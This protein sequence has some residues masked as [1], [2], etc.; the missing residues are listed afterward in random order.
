MSIP[1]QTIV[2]RAKQFARLEEMLDDVM[3]GRGR[4]C[5]LAGEAGSGKTTIVGE[6][7]RTAQDEHESLL[8]VAGDCNQ[9]TGVGDPYLPF[10]EILAQLA[11]EVDFSV[12][13]GVLSQESARRL[14]SN[15]KVSGEMILRV[16]AD[17]L[18][19]FVP[20]ASLL[21]VLGGRMLSGRSEARS[22]TFGQQQIFEQYT[23][24]LRNLAERFPIILFI[25][26]L[27]WV[28]HAS[29]ELLFHLSRRIEGSRVM[30]VGTYRPNDL[31][32]R[33]SGQPHPMERTIAEVKRYYGDAVIET[34]ERDP[35]EQRRFVA[36]L[37]AS[38][39]L[40]LENGFLDSILQQTDGHP[41]FT[42][43]LLRS[44][45]EGGVLARDESGDFLV[46]GKIEWDSLP[47]R[48][49]GII[50]GR[51]SRLDP[52]LRELLLVSSVQGQEFVAEAA[53]ALLSLEENRVVRQ[54]S[55]ELDRDHQLVM[56]KRAIRV[57]EKRLSVYRFRH[58][59]FQTYLYGSLDP[60]R[61]AYLH[62]DTG[63]ILEE[64]Y[65]DH[66]SDISVQLA[67]HFAI[68]G[69]D[70][71]AG[72][73]WV[74]AGD[75]AGGVYAYPEAMRHYRQGLEA[76]ARLE[77]SE[78][79]FR[80][81]IDATV[82]LARVSYLGE[83]PNL[84]LKRLQ[85]VEPLAETLAS[86]ARGPGDALRL[87]RVQYWMGRYHFLLHA[88]KAAIALYRKV[89]EV[90]PTLNDPELLALPASVIGRAFVA[91]GRFREA[92]PLL[93]QAIG[94][95]EE[96][97]NPFE[98][99]HTMNFLGHAAAGSGLPE[100]A[101][102]HVRAAMEKARQIESP[103]AITLSW[104]HTW[105]TL[106]YAGSE[107]EMLETGR[108]LVQAARKSDEPVALYVGLGFLAWSQTRAGL[109]EEAAQSMSRCK[110]MA[111]T[112]GET[113]V[114]ADWFAAV[115][116]EIALG[117][118]DPEEACA[119]ALEA[120]EMAEAAGG[121]LAA[122]LAHR[123]WGVALGRREAPWAEIEAHF[124]AG[125]DAAESGGIRP[126]IARIHAIW[127][128]EAGRRGLQEVAEE[129]RAAALRLLDEGV[130]AAELGYLRDKP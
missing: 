102:E 100:M 129:H 75:A 93:E 6:F 118:D 87:A 67:R 35:T 1:W 11:G 121:V 28:D 12:A 13:E 55:S 90:A 113:M 82:K 58:N 66:V 42:V 48:I 107:S 59:L 112:L 22:S 29:A 20:G 92:L 64:L 74:D 96:L 38:E 86:E 4:V 54:L 79:V 119:L 50:E 26:D 76:L 40:R 9:Q 53:A 116:A 111:A 30:I 62:E 65:G 43:E 68:A 99:I 27:Q 46:R 98:W 84:I 104:I 106:M 45:A 91:Q 125:L 10:R 36:T 110:E 70:R 103:E 72:R 3:G 34:D 117:R 122:A 52:D 56:A 95:L 126:E 19:I 47:S 25:D 97:G 78:E 41:L 101:S 14:R 94:P 15:V 109:H 7:S 73:Y 17:L 114:V 115:E 44:L 23:D 21:A 105:A 88:P 49:E 60:V 80:S 124:A 89:V 37:L 63:R 8:L 83:S 123:T 16:G 31:A 128:A 39:P 18:D 32:M 33:R 127:S 61:K 108:L 24:I 5:F 51:I 130:G 81:R 69:D 77:S 85:E 57:G 120:V 71:R 2:P